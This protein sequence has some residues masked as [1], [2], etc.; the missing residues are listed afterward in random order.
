M[1]DWRKKLAHVEGADALER[2]AGTMKRI[3]HEDNKTISTTQLTVKCVWDIEQSKQTS[4][5]QDRTVEIAERLEEYE[6]QGQ[7]T[8]RRRQ[9]ILMNKVRFTPSSELLAVQ[10]LPTEVQHGMAYGPTD[11]IDGQLSSSSSEIQHSTTKYLLR[12]RRMHV[13]TLKK[14]ITK[15]RCWCLFVVYFNGKLPPTMSLPRW[16][17]RNRPQ[18]RYNQKKLTHAIQGKNVMYY[19]IYWSAMEIKNTWTIF[20]QD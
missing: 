11:E 4:E 18:S 3:D 5:C 16:I 10:Q 15:A 14:A 9:C 19:T 1:R 13:L 8:R 17:Y 2:L 20:K 7:K 6:T 12:S